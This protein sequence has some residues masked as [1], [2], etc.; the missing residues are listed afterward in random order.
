MKKTKWIQILTGPTYTQKI[1]Q[2]QMD[3]K[4]QRGKKSH[5]KWLV[6]WWRMM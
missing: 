6:E 5:A 3:V 4:I 2:K 1:A